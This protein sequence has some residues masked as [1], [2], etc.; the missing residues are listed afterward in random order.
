VRIEGGGIGLLLG[1]AHH[2]TIYRGLSRNNEWP[3]YIERALIVSTALG[4]SPLEAPG[5]GV[6]AD[7]LPAQCAGPLVAVMIGAQ[8]ELAQ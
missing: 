1:E 4:R 8:S 7:Y 3:F 6:G 2:P 5:P